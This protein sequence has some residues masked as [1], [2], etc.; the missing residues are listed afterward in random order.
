MDRSIDHAADD[1]DDDGVN[2]RVG[3]TDCTAAMQHPKIWQGSPQRLEVL[4]AL[5]ACFSPLFTS[6][7]SEE[8]L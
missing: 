4:H 7:E 3:M 8:M 5:Y 1:D 2:D 6:L